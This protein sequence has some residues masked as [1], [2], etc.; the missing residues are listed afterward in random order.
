[1]FDRA[2]QIA[3]DLRTPLTVM[4]STVNNLLDGAF[5]PL[6]DEQK[7]WLKKLATHTQKLESLLQEILDVAMSIP[8]EAPLG[9]TPAPAPKQGS[10]GAGKTHWDRPPVVVVIDD[11]EDIRGL[12]QEVMQNRG[13][14]VHIGATADEA[15]RLAREKQP[16]VVL[17]DVNLGDRN[18][19]EV[20]R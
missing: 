6:N 18:G 3:H 1:M 4:V 20:C 10:L 2:S 17:L 15:L 7:L 14:E 16:D 19:I 11:E 5:G 9:S 13:F 12:I 8:T